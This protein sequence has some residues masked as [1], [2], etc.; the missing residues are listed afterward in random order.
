MPAPI[1]DAVLRLEKLSATPAATPELNPPDPEARSRPSFISPR[2][3]RS[4][5]D[6]DDDDRGA[7]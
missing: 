6:D 1:L 7:A 5:D 4:L 2:L 3:L